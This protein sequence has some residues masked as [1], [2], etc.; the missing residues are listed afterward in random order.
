MCRISAG[1]SGNEPASCL[2]TH[3]SSATAPDAGD[4]RIDPGGLAIIHN[5][6][7]MTTVVIYPFVA[8]IKLQQREAECF[9]LRPERAPCADVHKIAVAHLANVRRKLSDLVKL[10]AILAENG[11]AM[12]RRSYPRLPSA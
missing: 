4:V 3:R 2:L 8:E 7:Y 11:C 6:A 12:L 5:S 9:A 10:E 1:V